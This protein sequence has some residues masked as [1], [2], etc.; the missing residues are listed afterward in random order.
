VCSDHAVVE[1]GDRDALRGARERLIAA[2]EDII[3][4]GEIAQATVGA[5]ADAAGVHRVTFY[6]HYPDKEALL[7][8][9][10]ELRTAPL[11]EHSARSMESGGFFPHLLI[12]SMATAIAE[13]RARP[14]L[15][16]ALGVYPTDDGPHSAGTS[17][18]FRQ[19][20]IDITAPHVAAAQ[21]AGLLRD[22]LSAEEIVQWL[23]EVCLSHLLFR[24]A[25][26]ED[27]VRKHLYDFVL[28]ALGPEIVGR[29]QQRE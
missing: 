25:D 24:P 1:T 11:F 14:G 18:R 10:L 3:D 7:A 22:D 23:L 8:E 29:V 4:R 27:A 20:A 19:R 13:A 2:A 17:E 12:D 5:I 6:R 28:P 16:A 26:S 15:I 9:V 21:T